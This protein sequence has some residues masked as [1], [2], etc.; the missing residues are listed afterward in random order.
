MLTRWLFVLVL[1]ILAGC[2][3]TKEEEEE[4]SAVSLA[5]SELR[6]LVV[7]NPSLAEA[8]RP[9]R[10]QWKAESGGTFSV[11]EAPLEEGGAATRSADMVLYPSG[12]LG[13]LA[14][15]NQII[16][17]ADRAAAQ[18]AEAQE[19]GLA[20]VFDLL[21]LHESRW[22]EAQMAVSLGSPRLVCYY[23][24]DL[25]EKLRLEPPRT[26]EEY[27]RAAEMLADREKLGAAAPG[28]D[29]PW[30]GTLEPLGKGWGGLTLLARAASYAKHVEHYSTLFDMESMEPLIAGP[31]FERALQELAAVSEGGNELDPDGVRAAFWRGECGMALT[32]PSA[33]AELKAA[34]PEMQVAFVDL[35]AA[36]QVYHLG[37]RRWVDGRNQLPLLAVAGV[38][39]SVT[40]TCQEED[41]PAARALLAFLSGPKWSV[42]LASSTSASTLFR[43]GQLPQAQEFVEPPVQAGPAQQYGQVVE[44]SLSKVEYLSAIRI[45]GR[46]RYLK[47]LDAAVD[48]AAA[49]TTLPRF[50]LSLAARRWEQVTEELGKERQRRAYLRS[51]GLRH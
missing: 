43:R 20:G 26:W 40:R 22:G 46:D 42:P 51:L 29:S 4:S 16:A 23:R 18:T 17:L 41:L 8:L 3:G 49:G 14:E 35:P 31:P 32:W 30:H 2:N 15:R 36:T 45:P 10:G 47:A 33:T 44:T 12:M 7:G 6:V 39:G 5:G 28:E 19:L 25:F 38:L 11:V 1:L 34:N 27:A 50:A 48:E 37:D 13:E 9:L 24:V 21:V